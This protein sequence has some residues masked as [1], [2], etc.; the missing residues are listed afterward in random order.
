MK[1]KNGLP[2]VFL[3]GILILSSL[4]VASASASLGIKANFPSKHISPL[5]DRFQYEQNT[6]GCNSCNNLGPVAYVPRE[7]PIMSKESWTQRNEAIKN[8]PKVGINPELRAFA[9]PS[10]FSLLDH[11]PSYNDRDQGQ[12][13]NCWVWGCTAPIEVAH[14]VQ[15]GIR[16]RLSIQFLD[17]NYNGGSGRY[18]ACCGGNELL[19]QNFY[20]SQGKFIPLV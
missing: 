1:K 10:S 19:F 17:S 4:L 20:S 5:L 12:C 13:G 14:D 8:L 18:W 7:H 2:I 9:Y 3:M 16:D 6:Y 15:N 11:I